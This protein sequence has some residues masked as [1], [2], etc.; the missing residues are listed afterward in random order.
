M[1][2]AA[3]SN[4]DS[5]LSCIFRFSENLKTFLRNDEKISKKHLNIYGFCCIIDIEELFFIR[6]KRI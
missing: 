6:G 2:I 3:K 5:I 1:S 4:F